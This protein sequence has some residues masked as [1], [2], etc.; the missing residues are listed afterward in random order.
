MPKTCSM[1]SCP[2]ISTS[3]GYSWARLFHNDV[4]KVNNKIF[5]MLVRGRLVVKVSADQATALIA[6]NEAVAF[7]P[8]NGRKMKEWVTA[9]PPRSPTDRSW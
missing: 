2:P 3:P 9:D 4:L 6:A 1:V 7:E 8:R 5:A